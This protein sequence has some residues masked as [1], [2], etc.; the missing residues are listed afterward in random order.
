M[1][2]LTMAV[3]PH[4]PQDI[5]DQLFLT[6]VVVVVSTKKRKVLSAGVIDYGQLVHSIH[7]AEHSYDVKF[8]TSC[9]VKRYK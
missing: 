9:Q 5:E 4:H 6:A 3:R 7:F 1:E 8:R 2:K